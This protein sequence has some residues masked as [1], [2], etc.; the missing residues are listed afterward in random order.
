MSAW[1]FGSRVRGCPCVLFLWFFCA[2]VRGCGGRVA[3]GSGSGGRLVR[4]ALRPVMGGGLGVLGPVVVSVSRGSGCV[5]FFSALLGGGGL[6]V[7]FSA[8]RF[9]C[10]SGFR[11]WSSWSCR[12]WGVVGGVGLGSGFFSPASAVLARAC[13]GLGWVLF[14]EFDPG[15]GRTL[16]ACLTH[17]SRTGLSSFLGV[18]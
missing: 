3:G 18:G 13:L 17:A 5:R 7:F 1:F 10:S 14:G 12:G 16:A 11:C 9:S 15:S 2:V 8:R 4:P 6:G